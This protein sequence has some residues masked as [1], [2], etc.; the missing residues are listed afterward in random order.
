N[1]SGDQ[2]AN[3]AFYNCIDSAPDIPERG[4]TVPLGLDM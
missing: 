1:V 3:N 4:K 2:Q